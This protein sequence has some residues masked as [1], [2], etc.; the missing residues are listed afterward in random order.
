MTA[1]LVIGHFV[2]KGLMNL[3]VGLVVFGVLSAGGLFGVAI[4][5]KGLIGGDQK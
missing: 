3:N 2:S 5:L 1:V 4:Y